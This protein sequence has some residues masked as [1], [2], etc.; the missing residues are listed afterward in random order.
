MR[1]EKKKMMA[2]RSSQHGQG[3]A[4]FGVV[5]AFFIV[6]VLLGMT[7]LAREESSR[8][9]MHQ[10]AR[11]A[12]WERTVWY[13]SGNTYITKSDTDVARE[14]TKRVYA[15]VRNRVDTAS[16]HQA[17]NMS[18]DQLDPFLYTADYQQGNRLP[19][20]RPTGG[21]QS[22]AGVA[23]ARSSESN[24]IAQLL[25][26]AGS[27]LQLQSEGIATSTV[28]ADLEVIPQIRNLGV[29]PAAF[30]S[31]SKNA[32]LGGAWNADGTEGEARAVKRTVLTSYLDNIPGLNIIQSVIGFL[33][34]EFNQLDLG[35]VDTEKMACQRVNGL[36]TNC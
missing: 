2:T 15:P 6:P 33:F 12:A 31:Q 19:I 28:S 11:Y 17:V 20:F 25:N 22:R 35:H 9:H 29:L 10:A 16:D 23:Y 5:A 27:L 8:Q 7:W 18:N 36:A 14:I 21:Q 1:S 34:P 32:L 4:E 26:G 24:A 13:R 3:M 30:T